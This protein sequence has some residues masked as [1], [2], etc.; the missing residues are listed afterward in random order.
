M[1]KK[2]TYLQYSFGS[3]KKA[4][5]NVGIY[6]IALTIITGLLIVE[7]VR[8]SVIGVIS[9]LALVITA[10]ALGDYKSYKEYLK[11]NA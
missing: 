4:A 3:F 8:P 1:D 11:R 9:F 2:K 6:G 5:L 10:N 7:G